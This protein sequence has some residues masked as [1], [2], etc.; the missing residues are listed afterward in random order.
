MKR[1]LPLVLILL[2]GLQSSLSAQG[3]LVVAQD[4]S[5]DHASIQDA[6]DATR[7]LGRPTTI[8]IKNGVYREKLR[9][10]SWKR[11]LTLVGESRTGTIIRW[12]DHAG[13]TTADGKNRSTFETYTFQV[14]GDGVR[15][16]NLTIENSW[17][18]PGQAVALHVEGDRFVAEDCDILGCQ[19]SL[20]AGD[21]GSRQYYG[22]CRI[23]GT[24]DFIFGSA[25]AVFEN[26]Q[27]ISK[28]DSYITA[29]STPENQE[30]G[31]V[32]LDC[33]LTA[34][35][36]VTKVY[37]GRPWRPF[38]K[39]VF[40]QCQLGGHIRAEGWHPWP[41]DPMFP[42]KEKTAYFAEYGNQGEGAPTMERVPWS[43][44]LSGK[45][46]KKYTLENIFGGWIPEASTLEK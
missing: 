26:C 30:F 4:G 19:D 25:T 22:N 24:T 34:D 15:L 32:F 29:A 46:M 11:R 5:G 6:I 3:T 42:E 7:D 9:I 41:G 43:R 2:L 44:Q 18:G 12:D 17:C 1:N 8:H 21:G 27:I 33:E 23:S 36:G 38:A 31:L 14:L 28:K 45:A 13:Q 35:P 39:T 10:P 37:L 20:Y 16:R 40:I